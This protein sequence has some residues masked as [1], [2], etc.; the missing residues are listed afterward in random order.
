[1][2]N[3][4]KAVKV[5]DKVYWVG[6][7]DWGLREFHGYATTRGTTYNAYLVLAEKITL[8]DTVK[9]PFQDELL[10]RIASLVDPRRIEYIVSNHSEMDHSGC[11]PQ[12]MRAVQPQKVFASPMGVKALAGHFHLKEGIEAVKDGQTLSL[13]D[14]ELTFVETRM[15]HWPDSMVSFL[16]KQNVLFSQDAFG[17]HLAS[18]ARF[19]DELPP[20]V[21]DY[22]A[23]KYY[24]NILMPMSSLVIKLLERLP[25]LG[26]PVAIIAPDH[27]PIFRKDLDWILQRYAGWADRKPANKAVV[28]YDTMWGSTARMARA[29][30]E[31]LIAGG[32]RVV[33]MPLGANHRSDVVT[34]LLDAGA[35]L[36]G[37]PTL[38]GGMLP[39]VA[40]LLTYLKGLR[41]TKLVGAAFGSYGWN[42]KAVG[43]IAA[44]L[45]EMGVE[46]TGDGLEVNYVPDEESLARCVAL[47]ARV[48]GRLSERC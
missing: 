21:M 2:E 23:A 35:L 18:G 13:G 33:L 26:L 7:V 4:Y 41:P 6:A 28:T 15:L 37:S 1:M 25:K 32:T 27:G 42:G 17:M 5:A 40:D 45:D 48:A 14:M 34:E 43:Q 11:L 46:R 24:A 44:V 30:T 8:I 19:A 39:T 3:V 22:E 16:S 38:N 10:A 47:G 12:V 20:D 31:G 29:I 9:A 36:V